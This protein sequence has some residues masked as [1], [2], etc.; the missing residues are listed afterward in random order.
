VCRIYLVAG[1]VECITLQATY[2]RDIEG[3][4]HPVPNGD[5]RLVSNVTAE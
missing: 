4:L 5:I 2:L 3:K 1:G